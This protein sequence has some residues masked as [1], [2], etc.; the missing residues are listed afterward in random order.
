MMRIAVLLRRKLERQG[1][2]EMGS[3]QLT[4]TLQA[5]PGDPG[6]AYLRSQA[7]AQQG[8]SESVAACC[9]PFVGHHQNYQGLLTFS[10]SR[11]TN[12]ARCCGATP[13]HGVF[14]SV[15]VFE[16]A[17]LRTNP[18]IGS[19]SVHQGLAVLNPRIS[20]DCIPS[21]YHLIRSAG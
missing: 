14:T 7:L 10:A 2:M 20:Q 21:R 16:T 15:P 12:Q 5:N 1:R 8:H 6:L 4:P 17:N 13:F 3:W 9:L 19:L 18:Q 11:I